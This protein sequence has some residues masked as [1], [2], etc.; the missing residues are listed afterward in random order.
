MRAMLQSIKRT[1]RE[2][3]KG[4]TVPAD[5]TEP[6]RIRGRKAGHTSIQW[7]DAFGLFGPEKLF[8]IE[9]LVTALT[10]VFSLSDRKWRLRLEPQL[11]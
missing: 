8:E 9:M 3:E 2:G 5:Q 11:N 4:R 1:M 10:R 6:C 7:A